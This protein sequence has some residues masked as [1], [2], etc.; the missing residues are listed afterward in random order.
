MKE[1]QLLNGIAKE[2][3]IIYDCSADNSILVIDNFKK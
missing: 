3:L 2:I 1:V